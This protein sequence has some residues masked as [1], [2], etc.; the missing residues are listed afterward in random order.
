MG[1]IHVGRYDAQQRWLAK[2][3]NLQRHREQCHDN[4][5]MRKNCAFALCPEL[6]R[7]ELVMFV[8]PVCKKEFGRLKQYVRYHTKHGTKRFYCS[9]PCAARGRVQK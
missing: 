7:A 1:G 4:S 5:I 8:C 2:G 6:E 3:D 9:R